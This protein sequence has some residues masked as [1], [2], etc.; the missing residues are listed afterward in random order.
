MARDRQAQGQPTLRLACV[1]R[2]VAWLAMRGEQKSPAGFR[3][4]YI[5]QVHESAERVKNFSARTIP[6]PN[7]SCSTWPRRGPNSQIKL[8]KTAAWSTNPPLSLKGLRPF[9]RALSLGTALRAHVADVIQSHGDRYAAL[10]LHR[11]FAAG[12]SDNRQRFKRFATHS[13]LPQSR[14]RK[15]IGVLWRFLGRHAA[16]RAA[17]IATRTETDQEELGAAVPCQPFGSGPLGRATRSG[18]SIATLLPG[19]NVGA[20][21]RLS[22]P[23]GLPVAD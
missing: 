2:G 14:Q 12:T 20:N 16:E 5:S 4:A 18:L 3:R 9:H 8:R 22:P 19:A 1:P 21:N 7:W 23:T 6:T 10:G 15:L 17:A 13:A 11:L